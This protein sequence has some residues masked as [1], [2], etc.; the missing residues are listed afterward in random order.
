MTGIKS[1]N[2]DN[3]G[4]K[5]ILF[6]LLIGVVL[7]FP[8]YLF[9]GTLGYALSTITLDRVNKERIHFPKF[10]LF[11]IALYL[12][13]GLSLLWTDNLK[14]GQRDLEFKLL[15]LAAPLIF[16]F[17]NWK[18]RDLEFFFLF[19]NLVIFGIFLKNLFDFI[20]IHELSW[21]W[22]SYESNAM[23]IHPTYMGMYAGFAAIIAFYQFVF[24]V[25]NSVL[26]KWSWTKYL[27]LLFFIGN[28]T[29]VYMVS[30][31]AGILGLLL[32]VMFV[33]G[34]LAF[35]VLKRRTFNVFLIFF[36]LTGLLGVSYILTTAKFAKTTASLKAYI[37]DSDAFRNENKD[38]IQSDVARV[39]VWDTSLKLIAENPFGVGPGDVQQKLNQKYEEFGY[40]KLREKELNPHSQYLQTAFGIG[41][42]GLVLLLCIFG[43]SLFSGIRRKSL[44]SIVFGLLILFNALFE[45]ILELQVGIFFVVFFTLILDSYSNYKLKHG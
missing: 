38:Q 37:S 8:P 27:W 26:S 1:N 22:F 33:L 2:I 14:L 40:V 43:Y 30:S 34:A 18:K 6:A 42:P 36:F 41:I 25:E 4:L 23:N 16:T 10:Y 32:G 20:V 19:F 24:K 7:I 21:G 29:Y 28:S 44:L 5:G 12:L 31:K 11:F 9:F 15:L 35:K 13:F 3:I 39:L 45:S 17:I